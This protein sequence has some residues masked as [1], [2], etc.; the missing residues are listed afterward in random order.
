[1]SERTAEEWA[2]YIEAAIE[3]AKTDGFLVNVN[4]D[5]CGSA[6]CDC[7]E[8]DMLTVRKYLGQRYDYASVMV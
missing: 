7:Q 5:D 6:C 2:K 3:A 8:P 1:M 4:F